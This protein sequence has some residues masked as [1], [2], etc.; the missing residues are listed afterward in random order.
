MTYNFHVRLFDCKNVMASW[1]YFINGFAYFVLNK[2]LG[3]FDR[4]DLMKIS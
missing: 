4:S 2:R 3:G 1:Q